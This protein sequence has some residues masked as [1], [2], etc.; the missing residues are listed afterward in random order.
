MSIYATS[1][2]VD[3]G[4]RNEDVEKLLL[5]PEEVIKRLNRVD[6]STAPDIEVMKNQTVG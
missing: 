2:A 4:D 1:D 3:S 5:G 6:T